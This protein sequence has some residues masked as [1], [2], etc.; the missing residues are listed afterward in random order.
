MFQEGGETTERGGRR[1]PHCPALPQ[2]LSLPSPAQPHVA[3]PSPLP[4]M[5]VCPHLQVQERGMLCRLSTTQME[6]GMFQQ[7]ENVQ[8][9]R[10]SQRP[11]HV[12]GGRC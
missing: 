8:A 11:Q 10:M 7:Q 5:P 2:P 1:E 9:E 3:T 6:E 4:K 12:E